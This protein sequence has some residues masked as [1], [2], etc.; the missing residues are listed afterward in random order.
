MLEVRKP[1]AQLADVQRLVSRE[2]WART[3]APSRGRPGE[4][5]V[6]DGHVDSERRND[7]EPRHVEGA[8][9]DQGP[10]MCLVTKPCVMKRPAQNKTI[11]GIKTTKL[12]CLSWDELPTSRSHRTAQSE[13]GGELL[14]EVITLATQNN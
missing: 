13:L 10:G 7:C 6:A 8:V 11:S 4:P 3:L 14:N 5:D 2:S 9:P 12:S 1:W